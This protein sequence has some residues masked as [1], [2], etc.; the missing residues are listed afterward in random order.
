MTSTSRPALALATKETFQSRHFRVMPKAMWSNDLNETILPEETPVLENFR[1]VKDYDLS[2][3]DSKGIKI[4]NN[5]VS[6]AAAT[7]PSPLKEFSVIYTDRAMN[8]MA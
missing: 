6:S 5:K 7:F 8:L 2:A 3:K 4:V 1:M